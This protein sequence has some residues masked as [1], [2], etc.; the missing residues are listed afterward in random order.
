MTPNASKDLTVV[1]LCKNEAD[2]LQ[3]CVSSLKLA[4]QLLVLDSY[5]DDE[6]FERVRRSW[7]TMG[8]AP[9]DLFFLAREWRGFTDARNYSLNLVQTP[10]VLWIDSD[11]W[12]EADLE[13]F[14][15]S[16]S[17]SELRGNVYRV[18]RK[19]RYMGQ[20]IRHGGWYPDRKARLGRVGFC[21]WR[22]GPRG[23]DV[24]EDLYPLGEN[25][26]VGLLEGH[27]GHEPF[28]NLEEHFKTND[29]YSTLLAMGLA[30]EYSQGVRHPYSR[31]L[32]MIKVLVKFV[33][34]YVWKLGVLDGRAGF[35]IAWGSAQSLY[36]RLN[37]AKQF[38]L[39]AA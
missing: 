27:I 25:E 36:W 29:R 26:S 21:E 8:K 16:T 38:F 17:L 33:E 15:G 12:I 31:G 23:A 28:R 2:R 13:R 10:W 3:R 9:E 18:A 37:K 7:E 19:S 11:E 24:H 32:V 20:W 6:S 5:S 22:T 4:N 30:K 14:L 35:R 1:I 34:N 39:G